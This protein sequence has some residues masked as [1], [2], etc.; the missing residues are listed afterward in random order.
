V[1]V[2]ERGCA[3]AVLVGRWMVG[4]LRDELDVQNGERLELRD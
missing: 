4:V 3:D 2:F 1:L